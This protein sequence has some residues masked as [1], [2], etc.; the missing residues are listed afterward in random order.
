MMRFNDF[1]EALEQANLEVESV[2]YYYDQKCVNYVEIGF[3]G[4]SVFLNLSASEIGDLMSGSFTV[5]NRNVS[6]SHNY[7]WPKDMKEDLAC[8]IRVERVRHCEIVEPYVRVTNTVH[9]IYS[10]GLMEM[11]RHLRRMVS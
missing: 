4:S 6:V 7:N 2:K 10:D 3:C 11:I 9:H 8:Q 5:C 1:L